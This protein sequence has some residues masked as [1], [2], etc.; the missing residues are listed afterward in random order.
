MEHKPIKGNK[1]TT[2]KLYERETNTKKMNLM[3][4]TV[5]HKPEII[6]FNLVKKEFAHV[7]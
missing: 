2:K 5:T 7:T 1:L 4:P 3:K 6:K